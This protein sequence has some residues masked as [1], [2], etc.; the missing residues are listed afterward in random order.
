M[1]V[2]RSLSLA[3][4]VT[5]F[6]LGTASNV[7][8]DEF[9]IF[10]GAVWR[11]SMTPKNPNLGDLTGGFRVNQGVIYQKVTPS[12]RPEPNAESKV[13]GKE[14]YVGSRNRNGAKRTRLDFTDLRAFSPKKGFNGKHAAT[15]G[16]KGTVLMKMDKPGTW[17]GVLIA[18]DG[19]H[20]KFS[21]VRV[22]E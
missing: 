18:E 14:T 5:C 7:Q 15:E 13:V 22:R 4:L 8:A 11:F 12:P 10:E 2:A 3:C 20:W 1:I 21:C 17:S 19:R 16:I 6:L 9:G